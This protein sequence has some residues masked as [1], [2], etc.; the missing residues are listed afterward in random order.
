MPWNGTTKIMTAP[1]NLNNN[2]DIQ[3][4]SGVNSR[5]LDQCFINGDWNKWAKYKP[6]KSSKISP[7]TEA[8][9]QALNYG[10]TISVCGRN[11][12][13]SQYL[14]SYSS[15][16][17][18]D[19]PDG[20]AGEIYRFYDLL[21]PGA[22]TSTGYRG[23]A[24][25]FIDPLNCTF[26]SSYLLNRGNS[27][28]TFA[29][30]LNYPP[31]NLKEGSI[32]VTDLHIGGDT[33]D[34]TLSGMYFGLVFVYNNTYRLITDTYPV[35]AY[36]R[37]G[38]ASYPQ[39]TIAESNGA[40]PGIT[41]DVTYNVYPVFSALAHSSLTTFES[42]D[43]VIALPVSPFSFKARTA[44]ATQRM[45]IMGLRSYLDRARPVVVL[46]AMFASSVS[47]ETISDGYYEIRSAS[48]SGETGGTLWRSGLINNTGSMVSGTT[49]TVDT[50][51][52]NQSNQG[53]V[54][55]KIYRGTAPT[56]YDEAW[57]KISDSDIPE[58]IE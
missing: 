47:G 13:I 34:L 43:R 14:N 37:S 22:I 39:I 52:L 31:N 40:L 32:N 56:V 10:L 17:G 53:W 44:Q 35:S 6:V 46:R 33:E 7:L 12:N 2:G 26:P 42:T 4:A 50:G 3:Q 54:Y 15:Q 27:G 24:N 20:S 21:K 5:H 19:K 28:V 57:A 29:L 18:Y 51:R 38:V 49:Y 8:D 9:L 25:S 58:I 41:T 11:G 1:L 23:D 55:A 16:W 45:V 36:P 48:G 30:G